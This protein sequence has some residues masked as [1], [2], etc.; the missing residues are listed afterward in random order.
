[1]TETVMKCAKDAWAKNY[2]VF[3]VQFYGECW[4]GAS[5]Y[6]TYDKDGLNKIGC[7]EG[8]GRERNNYVYAFTNLA[9]MPLVHCIS[10]ASNQSVQEDKCPVPKPDPKMKLC[11]D[12]CKS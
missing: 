3:G 12:V 8:V 10:T 6:K 7:W 2:T 9:S 4:S 11:T 5:S 1:M